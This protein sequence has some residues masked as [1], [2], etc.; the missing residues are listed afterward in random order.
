MFI[1][2]FH[3]IPSN[4][5]NKFDQGVKQV[6]YEYIGVPDLKVCRCI[7]YSYIEVCFISVTQG[8]LR[9]IAFEIGYKRSLPHPSDI[10]TPFI[11]RN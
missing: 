10:I 9:N 11:F 8:E 5:L 1:T 7:D 3:N 4:V 6:T 2:K